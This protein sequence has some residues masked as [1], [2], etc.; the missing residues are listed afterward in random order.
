MFDA[1][2]PLQTLDSTG[3]ALNQV[4]LSAISL[5]FLHLKRC[6]C[7]CIQ[8]IAYFALDNI[9]KH[10]NIKPMPNQPMGASCSPTKRIANKAATS[11]SNKVKVMARLAGMCFKP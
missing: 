3:L 4:F 7:T 10:T 9:A 5:P 8:T 1:L 6:I 2:H 11:G